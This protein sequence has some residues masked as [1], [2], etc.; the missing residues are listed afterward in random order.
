MNVVH[1]ATTLE[2]GAGIG[3]LRY[4][5]SLRAAGVDS[6]VLVARPPAAPRADVAVFGWKK[7][8]LPAR[9]LLR[10][11]VDF[12]PAARLRRRLAA[13]SAAGADYELFSPPFSDYVPESHPWVAAAD[14]LNLHWTSGSLDWRRFFARTRQPVLLTLHDQNPYLGGFHYARDADQ[15]PRLAPLERHVRDLKRRALAGRRLGVV[16]NSRW[17][18]DQARA[19]GFFSPAT[20][21]ETIRYPLDAERYHPRRRAAA[22]GTAV[23]GFASESL[24]NRR[25][26]FDLLLEALAALPEKLRARVS[27]LSFGR[28]PAPELAERVRLPWRHLGYLEGDDAKADA[29]AAMDVFVAP[30]RAEAFGLTALEAQ[31]VGTP[32]VATRVGGLAEAAPH[33]VEPEPAALAD[34]IAALLNDPALR[35]TRAAEGR[36]LVLDHHAPDAIGPRLAAFHQE[37]LR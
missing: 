33:A 12:S 17:N 6:R 21:I 1:V 4:H 23:I 22:A 35:S 25:K 8:P 29:Y 13:A 14:L 26:G 37:L 9:V 11:G 18:A 7:R 5:E 24:A 20:P 32:V 34:A 19:S 3:L 28:P 16:A 31:A 36:R 30:S 15:N 10:L 27:L 2:G